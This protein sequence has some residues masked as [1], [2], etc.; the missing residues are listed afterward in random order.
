MRFT[1]S[2]PR[3]RVHAQ[4]LLPQQTLIISTRMFN[5]V[6]MEEVYN[7]SIVQQCRILEAD[8]LG[9]NVL[10]LCLNDPVNA[11]QTVLNNKE[12]LLKKD[13]SNLLI[14][15]KGSTHLAASIASKVSWRCLWD[16]TLEKR[17]KG[18]EIILSVFWEVC[19][20][21]SCFQCLLCKSH[22]PNYRCFENACEKHSIQ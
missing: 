5:S 21:A 12:Q 15:A 20:L 2:G 16:I 22:A 19:R 6:A 9:T 3:W 17:V 11:T 1:S 18:T 14:S 13:V 10:A 7:C 8:Q 4:P